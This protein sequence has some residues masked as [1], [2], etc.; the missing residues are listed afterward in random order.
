MFF[1]IIHP[2][3][4]VFIMSASLSKHFMPLPPAPCIRKLILPHRMLRNNIK[5]Y[6]LVKCRNNSQFLIRRIRRRAGCQQK[7]T[8]GCIFLTEI[9]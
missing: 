4:Q 5:F 8:V 6:S 9:V 2:P 3:N 7:H 1:M